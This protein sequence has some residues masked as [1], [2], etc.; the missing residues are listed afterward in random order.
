MTSAALSSRLRLLC[1]PPAPHQPAASLNLRGPED[2]PPS[3]LLSPELHPSPEHL[4]DLRNRSRSG[5]SPPGVVTRAARGPQ[6]GSHT[7]RPRRAKFVDKNQPH[8]LSLL[9]KTS[10]HPSYVSLPGPCRL[11]SFKEALYFVSKIY[12]RFCPNSS[13]RHSWESEVP[14]ATLT[15][16]TTQRRRPLPWAAAHHL[17]NP[18]TGPPNWVAERLPSF[19]RVRNSPFDVLSP[20]LRWLT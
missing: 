12:V 19:P 10:S 2:S 3:T 14:C 17:R 5:L 18:V 9:T 8:A 16:A 20:A 6:T 4:G 15:L 1:A 13:Q 7:P 11:F